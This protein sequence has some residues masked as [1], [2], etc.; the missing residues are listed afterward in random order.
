MV[1]TPWDRLN[2]RHSVACHCKVTSP[3]A[4]AAK[5]PPAENTFSHVTYFLTRGSGSRNVL[6]LAIRPYPKLIP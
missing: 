3:L 1:I 2:Q 5:A 4:Q 6:A